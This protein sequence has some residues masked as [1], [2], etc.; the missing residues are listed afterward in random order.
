MRKFI[1]FFAFPL[2]IFTV[3]CSDKSDQLVTPF[4]WENANVYFLLTDRFY[5]EE[6]YNDVNFDRTE[7]TAK[8]RGFMGGDIKGI[9]RK[10]NEGY[11][12]D[13]GITAIWFTPVVE[14]VHGIVDEGTGPTYGYHGYWAK[15]WTALDPNFG[16]EEDLAQLVET[17][18][19][20]GIRIILD[21]V[22]N[23]TGPV[24]DKDPAWPPEWVRTSPKCE[25]EDYESTVHCTLV[26]NLPDIRTNSDHAVGL[27]EPLKKKWN[28]EG[29]LVQEVAELDA[30]FKRTGFPE[31]PRHYI[32]KWLIDFIL[33][34]GVDGFRIDTAKHVDETTWDEL[35]QEAVKAFNTWKEKNPEKV[36]D[37][38][39]FFMV[40]EV[41]GYNISSGRNFD[42]GDT[43]VDFYN[44]GMKALI[45]FEFKAD[46]EKTYEEIFSK[47]SSLL[48]NELQGK[49]VFNYI[50]SHDDSYPFD[51][52][53]ENPIVAGTK[54]LLCP[55]VVQMYY[56][57]ETMRPIN[58]PGTEGDAALRSFMNWD[59]LEQNVIRNG[60]NVQ[61]VLHHWQKL[62]IFRKEHPA[63]GAG[64]HRKIS[65]EPYM[66]KRI[67]QSE[68]FEDVVMVGLDIE[69]G[70]QQINVDGSFENNLKLKEYYSGQVVEVKNNQVAFETAYDIILLGTY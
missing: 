48:K 7:K 32:I 69:P 31:S 40:G 27:P 35:W 1:L 52:L 29:R 62:G 26:K 18:H 43:L 13:L 56:G 22:L 63:V 6:T 19:K 16:T 4:I 20:N 50:S 15:D 11:F 53:R 37:D 55:G 58:V 70:P 34:Y 25:H 12:T 61:E 38:S 44:H 21:V 60:Y 51:E 65:D 54:L 67:F 57:D 28:D 68:D 33:E 5:N 39:E 59:E 41:Y 10:I 36:L 45:N 30:F 14:Q 66:F 17:A 49:T 46:A 3:S 8:L 24:T 2:L 9:T 47:Y 64:E 23:H 42:F